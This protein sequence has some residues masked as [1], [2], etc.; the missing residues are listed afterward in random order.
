MDRPERWNELSG[1]QQGA[2]TVAGRIQVL[3]VPL[4]V[5][6]G[7]RLLFAVLA[8]RLGRRRGYL[9]GFAC[10]WAGC[11]LLPPALLVPPLGAAGTQLIPALGQ[12]D[13]AQLG[14]AGALAAVNATGE[15]LLWRGLFV[16]MFP[17]GMT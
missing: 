3:A 1:R 7:M 13:P 8:R 5:P 17:G 14:T 16:V 11:Y 6:V 2:V 10:Y 9:A 12:A 15:E 4:V